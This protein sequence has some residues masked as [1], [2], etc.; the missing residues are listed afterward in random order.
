[1]VP[2]QGREES[3]SSAGTGN[4][5]SP[6]GFSMNSYGVLEPVVERLPLFFLLPYRFLQVLLKNRNFPDCVRVEYG[7]EMTGPL[8]AWK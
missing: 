1:M 8:M 3:E 6:S 5:S 4:D 2:L 7:A